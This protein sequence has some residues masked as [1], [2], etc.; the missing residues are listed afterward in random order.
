MNLGK[1]LEKYRSLPR[2]SVSNNSSVR[3]QVVLRSDSQESV[4]ELSGPPAA[5]GDVLVGHTRGHRG[6]L[7][8]PPDVQGSVSADPSDSYETV[9]SGSL[10][11][12]EGVL[13]GPPGGQVGV[14]SGPLGGHGEKV[15]GPSVVHQDSGKSF[16][17]D[18]EGVRGSGHDD[19][20]SLLDILAPL[21]PETT[22]N[23]ESVSSGH[24]S[25]E[26]DVLAGHPVGQGGVSSG[27]SSIQGGEEQG[28][29]AGQHDSGVQGVSR[30]GHEGSTSFLD[31]LAPLP[32]VTTMN[33]GSVSSGPPSGQGGVISGN[34]GGQG[35]VLSGHPSVLRGV[36]SGSLGGQGGEVLG[37]SAGVQ[38][39]GKSYPA[40]REG[41][42][43]TEQR[44]STSVLDILA[45]LPRVTTGDLA[46]PLMGE[47]GTSNHAGT[48][49]TVVSADKVW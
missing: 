33:D 16:P 11:G 28:P 37:H 6:V 34:P 19:M 14:L 3:E 4:N 35:G 1:H 23:Y 48:N 24:P 47:Q 20:T 36:L 41:M 26:R 7:S 12:Q 21:P 9:L 32:L 44:G 45:P 18:S 27:P 22:M 31:I 2:Q 5:Q 25:K 29:S 10:V 39:G 42:M 15:Q 17:A 38:G 49:A 13:S 40:D 43:R 30:K 8:G 46:P